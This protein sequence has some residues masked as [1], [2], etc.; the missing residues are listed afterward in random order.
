ML[1]G[2]KKRECRSRHP[3]SHILLSVLLESL[4]LLGRNAL[5]EI[6]IDDPSPNRAVWGKSSIAVFP[7]NQLVYLTDKRGWCQAAGFPGLQ[8]WNTG[9]RSRRPPGR[10]NEGKSLRGSR[11]SRPDVFGKGRATGATAPQSILMREKEGAKGGQ[12]Q[13]RIFLLF[14]AA[15][16][17][18]NGW[19]DRD[20]SPLVVLGAARAKQT[21][22]KNQQK[23]AKQWDWLTGWALPKAALHSGAVTNSLWSDLHRRLRDQLCNLS[24][25]APWVETA[26]GEAWHCWVS[27]EGFSVCFKYWGTFF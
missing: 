10:A 5:W 12:G 19:H 18:I 4:W 9:N 15:Q 7:C 8:W 3:A 26:G 1:K 21:E 27:L 11:V 16:S 22:E 24:E 6:V 13:W 2:R 25:E 20:L 17:D 14:G 23:Q